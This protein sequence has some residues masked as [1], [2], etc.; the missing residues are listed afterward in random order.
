MGRALE[1]ADF[2]V[3]L[4]VLRIHSLPPQVLSHFPNHYLLLVSY[5]FLDFLLHP[6]FQAFELLLVSLFNDSNLDLMLFLLSLQ[7]LL[8]KLS[9]L[10]QCFWGRRGFIG[11]P[12]Q[13]HQLLEALR[14]YLLLCGHIEQSLAKSLIEHP[15][16][17]K[18][19]FVLGI[20]NLQ[21]F[22]PLAQLDIVLGGGV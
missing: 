4:T 20:L 19:A 16:Y 14:T 21:R 11:L 15:S 2:N 17:F 22:Y 1:R 5:Q 7:L 3:L 12:R 13:L 6:L 18:F 9:K 10:S 8:V